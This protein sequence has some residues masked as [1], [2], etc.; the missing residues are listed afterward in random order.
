MEITSNLLDASSKDDWAAIQKNGSAGAAS[1]MMKFDE[2]SNKIFCRIEYTN[3]TN[4]FLFVK[5]T[6][7]MGK[8]TWV[9]HSFLVQRLI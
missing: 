6:K 9:Q 5:R 3:T 2:F 8:R 7:N 1:L 4:P